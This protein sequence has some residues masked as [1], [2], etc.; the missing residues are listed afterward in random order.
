MY[1]LIYLCLQDFWL[2]I[3][4]VDSGGCISINHVLTRSESWL[5]I[6]CQAIESL[7]SG[8]TSIRFHE[9]KVMSLQQR[10]DMNIGKNRKFFQ[11]NLRIIAFHKMLF[12]QK[13]PTN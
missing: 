13:M 7:R 10:Q 11:K 6:F 12:P 1:H 2:L 4:E 3:F 9:F 5:V 8:N